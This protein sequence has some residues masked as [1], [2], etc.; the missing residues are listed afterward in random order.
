MFVD[1]GASTPEGTFTK[2]ASIDGGL[3]FNQGDDWSYW[4]HKITY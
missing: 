3:T 2:N 4:V 1:C